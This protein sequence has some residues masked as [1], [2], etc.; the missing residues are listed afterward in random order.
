MLFAIDKSPGDPKAEETPA[1]APAEIKFRRSSGLRKRLKYP[2][3]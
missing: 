1:A 2:E 3:K